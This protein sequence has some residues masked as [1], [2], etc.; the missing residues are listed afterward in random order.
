MK[1]WLLLAAQDLLRKAIQEEAFVLEE[2]RWCEELTV[3]SCC[4][5]IG[6]C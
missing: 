6:C 2:S 4:D 3:K 1:V 5:W